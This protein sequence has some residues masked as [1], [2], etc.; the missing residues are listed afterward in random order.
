MKSIARITIIIL[1]LILL[2]AA[3]RYVLVGGLPEF[4]LHKS[5]LLS[6]AVSQSLAGTQ[7]ANSLPV[8]GVDYSISD[9]TYFSGSDWA[10]AT[11]KSLKTDADPATVLLHQIKGQYQ[12]VLGPGTAFPSSYFTTV[13]D[14]VVKELNNRGVIYDSGQ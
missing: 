13:P 7:N 2:T 8:E 5:G 1:G 3:T 12:V 11:I 4:K 6:G 14:G 9:I 10:V